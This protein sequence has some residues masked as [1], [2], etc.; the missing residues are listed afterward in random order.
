M[1]TGTCGLGDGA[2]C[3]V[4]PGHVAFLAGGEAFCQPPGSIPTASVTAWQL[5]SAVRAASVPRPWPGRPPAAG[6]AGPAGAT[7][8]RSPWLPLPGAPVA[9]I[10][11]DPRPSPAPP[12][13]IL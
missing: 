8:L 3:H 13:Y 12:S 9:L 6:G 4:T 1:L 2:V 7:E 5:N 11:H 10:D